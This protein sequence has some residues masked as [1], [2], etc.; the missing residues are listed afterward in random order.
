MFILL[1][2]VLRVNIH[3][4]KGGNKHHP[5]NANR[6]SFY[7]FYNIILITFVYKLFFFFLQN[8]SNVYQITYL[9]N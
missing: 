1:D 6:K 3:E 9:E 7:L 2:V 4:V 5:V 8:D